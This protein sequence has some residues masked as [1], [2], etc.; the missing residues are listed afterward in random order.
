MMKRTFCGLLSLLLFLSLAAHAEGVYNVK[1]Y[2]AR[3]N[4][5]TMDSPAI[6][7]AI[8]ACHKAGGGTVLVPAG[9][10]LSATI[11]LKDNV[12]LHLEKDALILGTTDYKAYDNPDPFTEGLGID[13][14]WALM[15]AIDA[16]N[17]TLEGEGTID[18]QGSALKARHILEDTRPEGQRWGVRP[19]LL[20][21][22]RCENVKVQGVTLKYAGAWTSHYFQCRHV[23][24]D[25]V[26]IRS[27]GVAHNDGINIDGCQHVRISNCD[28]VSGDDA[29]CFKTTS[30]KMGCD[31]VVVTDMKLKSN[32]AGIKMGTESMAGFE[33]IKISRCHIYD[34]RNGG[35]KLF[36]VDGAHLRNVEISDITMDEVR[37]PM[38]FRLGARLSVFRKNQ[39]SRQPVGVFENVTIRNVDAVAADKAQ[40]TPPSGILITGIP[41]HYITNLTL[42][43][44]HVRLLGTGTPE[45][46]LAVVPE[47]V[48]QYPEV[49][50]F[51]PK[52]PAYGVWARHV[53][54]LKLKNVT[55]ELKNPDARPE[56]ICEDGDMQIMTPD[57]WQ[58][59]SKDR[60]LRFVLENKVVEGTAALYYSVYYKNT[61]V[62]EKSLLGLVMDDEEYGKNAG[63]VAATPVR[64]IVEP[65]Q[66]K[67]GKQMKTVNDCREQ[68]F[69]FSTPQGKRFDFTVRVYDDGVAFRYG[70]P[71]TDSGMHTIRAEHTE[72]AVPVDGKAWIHPYDW[73]DRKKPS[74]EQYCENGIAIRSACKHGRGWAFPMLFET[75]GAWM[76]ITEAC[77][78]GTYPATHVDNSGRNGAYKI[79]FPEQDEPIVPDA[80]QP[81]SRLPWH[82]PWR[83]VIVGN[84]LDAVFRTQMISHL[85]PPSIVED[86]SWIKAGRSCWSWW[87]RGASVRDYKEQIK[88]VDLSAEMGWEYILIDAGWQQMGN[89]GTMED[90][91]KYARQKGVGVWLWY[92]SGAGRESDT[93]AARRLMCDPVLRRAEMKRISRL[94]VKGIKVD[95]F[96]TDKQR[97]IGLYPAI[98]KD[99]A[100]NHLMVDLHGAT[101]PRG[102]ERTYPNLM[103]TEAIRGAETLGRQERCDRAAGH[104]AT[105]PFTRNVVG[106]MDYTPVTFSNKIRQG[107]EAVR[108]TTVAH[109]LAL[110]VVFESG[111][112]CFADRAEAYLSLPRQPRQFLKDVPAAWDESCLLAGYPGDYA[113]V[114]RRRGQRW[115]IGG[116]NGK[117]EERVIEFALPVQ[118]R[119]KSFTLITDGKDKDTFD[120]KQVESKDGMLKVKVLPGGGFAGMIEIT[121]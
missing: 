95:F 108:R 87:Y 49:K 94:G 58:L 16:R 38:L 78:D 55:F 88:Y 17:V 37:T 13:V 112:Q 107:V 119:G 24:I 33:N 15:V 111:F 46:A 115:F 104:N 66:L 114:A 28:I 41:G 8:D 64:S 47:A 75:N 59:A 116:I 35:I 110:A 26:T 102:F 105:V 44:I 39:D 63:F 31:D 96:D 98:L 52:I 14:G 91:V 109:Q 73:N 23:T 90:V 42:E 53:K 27:F 68:T 19:F 45:D 51:G 3:G 62:I 76:M 29:L 71:D 11:V 25:G 86:E 67:S 54:G 60:N 97:I 7:R 61:P 80:P 10:Y 103:T 6:Q 48:D 120:N 70:F 93:V 4:G 118:C 32:Q 5:K 50:T 30:S 65:Y 34:T 82:T 9:T 72:F 18:G 21:W 92:H 106:S 89:G 113:V 84:D 74:Y 81:V 56:I 101:L 69:T 83:A 57:T 99:A 77:L 40:L 20:R 121:E 117:A 22:V 43:N 85:N 2:G 12:T 100:D 79:R 1:K 36:S